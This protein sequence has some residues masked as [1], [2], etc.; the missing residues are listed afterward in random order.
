VDADFIS[1]EYKDRSEEIDASGL[2]VHDFPWGTQTDNYEDTIALISC[3]DAVVCVPTTAYHA[4]GAL[5][6]PAIVMVHDT[7]SLS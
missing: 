1:L 3:L 7:P 6:V 4:A 5:G 2:T